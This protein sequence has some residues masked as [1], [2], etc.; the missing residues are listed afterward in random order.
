MPPL[1]RTE[2]LIFELEKPLPSPDLHASASLKRVNVV[3]FELAYI[4][5]SPSSPSTLA[6]SSDSA[7]TWVSVPAPLESKVLPKS[8]YG[9]PQYSSPLN[10]SPGKLHRRVYRYSSPKPNLYRRVLVIACARKAA[11][12]IILRSCENQHSEN[13]HSE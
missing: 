1:K 4:S 9:T 10:P 5:S 12:R 2:S 6:N 3:N 11:E 7:S 8:L 13:Q